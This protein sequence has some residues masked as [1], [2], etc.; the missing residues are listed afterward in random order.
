MKILIAIFVGL[1]AL[2]LRAK[3]ALAFTSV[4]INQAG[5]ED[6]NLIPGYKDP[7]TRQ[8]GGRIANNTAYNFRHSDQMLWIGN[9]EFA[10]IDGTGVELTFDSARIYTG[11]YIQF[12]LG[13]WWQQQA[14]PRDPTNAIFFDHGVVLLTTTYQQ[15]ITD[16]EYDP[17]TGYVCSISIRSLNAGGIQI[18]ITTTSVAIDDCY[19]TGLLKEL[20][21]VTGS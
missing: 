18:K 12:D 15:I 17:N 14:L 8:W 13:T 2:L 3:K 20:R 11:K 10:G 21:L 6:D 9:E 16:M 19:L 7:G 4:D 1:T 5:F